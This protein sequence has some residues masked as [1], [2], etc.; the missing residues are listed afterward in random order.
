MKIAFHVYH[1]TF[2][3]TEIA[4]FDYALFNKF[5][6]GNESIIVTPKNPTQPIN[7]NVLKKFIKEFKIF[8]YD[9]KQHL[10]E[11]CECECINA[12]YFIKYGTN[13][14]LI[15]DKIPSLIHCVFTTQDP[16]GTIYAGV[17]DSVSSVNRSLFQTVKYPVV[18]HMIYLPDLKSDYRKDLNIPESAIVFGRHGGSDTFDI[19]FVK[20]VILKILESRNDVYFIFCEKPMLL[21]DVDHERILCL[22]SFSDTRIKRK[23]INTCDAMIHASSLGESFGLSVLEFSYCNKPVITWNGGLLHKQ[24]LVNLNSKAIIYSNDN[25]LFHILKTYERENYINN[26]W[27]VTQSFT[28]EKIMN[29]FKTVFLD[30]L[31]I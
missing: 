31:K 21:K 12:I 19:P 7:P 26:D 4:T 11:I 9:N 28:P 16:H 30:S 2:R 5:L 29:Q 18:N 3:G 24:H 8:E 13:D 14:G 6:L 25:E 17:S 20:N 1:L 22:E 27:D 23:F 15:L 10:Q